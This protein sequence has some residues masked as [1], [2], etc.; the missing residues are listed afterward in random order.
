EYLGHSN[1][2]VY[3]AT[4]W[5]EFLRSETYTKGPGSTVAR[6]LDGTVE[7]KTQ[8]GIAG[9]AN[10]GSDANWTGHHFGQANWY[11]YGRLA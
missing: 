1:H 9:V 2:L 7:G 5:T 11:A 4:M 3:L 8:T 6:V 10:T